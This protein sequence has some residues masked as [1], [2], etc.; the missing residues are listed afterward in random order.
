[1]FYWHL[2]EKWWAVIFIEN[3]TLGSSG[4]FELISADLWVLPVN[5]TS[6]KNV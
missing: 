2:Q 5:D 1:M 4:Y 3:T 6:M